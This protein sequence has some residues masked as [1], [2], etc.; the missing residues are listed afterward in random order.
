MD[1]MPECV[2]PIFIILIKLFFNATAVYYHHVHLSLLSPYSIIQSYTN[3]EITITNETTKL[4]R[5]YTK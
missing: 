5:K 4:A 3:I 1:Q 2:L